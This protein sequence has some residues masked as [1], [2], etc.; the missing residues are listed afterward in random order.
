MKAKFEVTMAGDVTQGQNGRGEMYS[1]QEVTIK[2]V[3]QPEGERPF[4]AIVKLFNKPELKLG[5]KIE[6]EL[7][8]D[9]RQYGGKSYNQIDVMEMTVLV[10]PATF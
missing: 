2:M 1:M 5:D 4:Y 3:E 9:V 7:R 10:E 8:F 6:A